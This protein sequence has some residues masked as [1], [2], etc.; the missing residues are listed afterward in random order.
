MESDRGGEGGRESRIK[1]A[2]CIA[3]TVCVWKTMNILFIVFISIFRMSVLWFSEK[4]LLPFFN[5]SL[6]LH[7]SIRDSIVQGVYLSVN[8]AIF[9]GQV[10]LFLHCTLEYP[11]VC[12]FVL[13]H[14]EDS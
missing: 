1:K 9:Q 7:E 11:D 4:I 3:E 13:D 6:T 10:K 5:V 14:I 2:R 8:F 12:C